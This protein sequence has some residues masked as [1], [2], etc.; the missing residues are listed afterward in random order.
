VDFPGIGES[1][2][3]DVATHRAGVSR[4]HLRAAAFV[5]LTCAAILGVSAWREWS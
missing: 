4:L 5:V 1:T 3:M 2:P